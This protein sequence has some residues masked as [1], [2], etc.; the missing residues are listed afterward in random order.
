MNFESFEYQPKGT[1]KE[2]AGDCTKVNGKAV[3]LKGGI[4]MTFIPADFRFIAGR[5][6]ETSG[7]IKQAN[8]NMIRTSHHSHLPHM[9]YS[10]KYGI[11]V[12]D[13]ANHE[14]QPDGSENKVLGDNLTGHW[15]MDRA[16]AVVEREQEPNQKHPHSVIGQRGKRGANLRAMADTIRAS[17]DPTR[18]IYDDTDRT[19]SDVYD[20]AHLHPD[21]LKESGE[22]NNRPPRIHERVCSRH[23]KFHRQ[24]QG[25]L[26]CD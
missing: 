24:P 6:R 14:S 11:Y 20:E 26:G 1:W 3:K 21:A 16:V 2:I 15:P 13:E 17:L 18:P 9:S 23:G 8:I 25:V 4:V 19:V 22:K 10:D 5:W 12:M 7:W